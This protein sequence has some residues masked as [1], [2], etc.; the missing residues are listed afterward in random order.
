MEDDVNV[1]ILEKQYEQVKE[2]IPR[3]WIEKVVEE[4]DNEGE[5]MKVF[6][7][8]KGENVS[9]NQY[10]VKEMYVFFRNLVF[11]EPIALKF[12]EK[13]FKDFDKMMLWKH[14]RKWYM[15]A[16]MEHLD[17]CIKN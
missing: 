6:I 4:N 16:K 15:D 5:K 10:S 9:F 8:E 3:K 14:L 11:K 17:F 13:V 1:K 2:A 12:W 7:K